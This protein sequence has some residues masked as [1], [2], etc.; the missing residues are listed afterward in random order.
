MPTYLSILPVL[1]ILVYIVV[2]IVVAIYVLVLMTRFVTAHQRGAQA[3][4]RVAA[5]MEHKLP[6]D[7]P[8]A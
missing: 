2:I 3:L 8:P 7:D 4:E 1:F 6:R 5:S